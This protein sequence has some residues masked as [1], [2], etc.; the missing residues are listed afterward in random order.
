MTSPRAFAAV[1]AISAVLAVA[2]LRGQQTTTPERVDD[3]AFRFRSS[4]ELINV[5]TTVYDSD[6]RFVPGLTQDDFTIYEDNKLQTITHF[7]ADRVPVSLGIVLDTSGSMAGEKIQSA[8]SALD[9]FLHELLGP[10]RRSVPLP[11][12]RRPDAGAGLDD[13]LLA[14]QP[15]ARA[16][17]AERGDGA[18][19]RR[20]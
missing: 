3:D 2:T 11:L 8:R 20:S 6:G 17:R 1:G 12:Q 19:R 13:R 14:R 16:H 7:N 18:V 4:V 10:R 15:R 9:R 5:A